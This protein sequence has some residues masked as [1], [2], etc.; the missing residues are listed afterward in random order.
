MGVKNYN[1]KSHPDISLSDIIGTWKRRWRYATYIL[2]LKQNG[3][4]NVALGI[5]TIWNHEEIIYIKQGNYSYDSIKNRIT[6]LKHHAKHELDPMDYIKYENPRNKEFIIV[7]LSEE[8]MT[9]V[10]GGTY[11]TQYHK[12]RTFSEK[13][14]Y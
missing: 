5:D 6:L 10:E 14:I 4:Y 1:S 11:I 7:N 8:T 13:S 9:L 2:T 3:T 12:Q